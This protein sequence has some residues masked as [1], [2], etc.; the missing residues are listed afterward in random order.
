MRFSGILHKRFMSHEK[1]KNSLINYEN[2]V[3]GSRW[4]GLLQAT[5]FYGEHQVVE[6]LLETFEV[7]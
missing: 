4:N 2:F 3:L 7:E 6:L 5:G 1:D